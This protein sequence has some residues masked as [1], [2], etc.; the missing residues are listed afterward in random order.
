RRPRRVAPDQHGQGRPG[1]PPT[2]A[3]TPE[4]PNPETRI[5]NPM[6]GMAMT[7]GST[8][9]SLSPLTAGVSR[10]RLLIAA[11][12][13]PGFATPLPPKAQAAAALASSGSRAEAVNLFHDI[14]SIAGPGAP[15]EAT[16]IN[17]RGDVVGVTSLPGTQTSHAFIMN[18]HIR[19]GR[20][21]DI[22]PS[23]P[24]S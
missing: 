11:A 17:D 8:G 13:A 18:P 7:T 21:T 2:P 10:R 6:E 22:M 24:R 3:V 9:S 20:L 15:S 14:G 16:D 1:G 5:P 19:G 23:E 12:G 4:T